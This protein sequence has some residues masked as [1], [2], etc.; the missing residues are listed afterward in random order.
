[1]H[2]NKKKPGINIKKREIVMKLKTILMSAQYQRIEEACGN[3]NRKSK[4]SSL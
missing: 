4:H 2:K 1:M 3:Q